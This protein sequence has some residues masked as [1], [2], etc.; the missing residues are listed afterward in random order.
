M[1]FIFCQPHI[2]LSRNSSF[3]DNRP[4]YI[5]PSHNWLP[6]I[7][8][9]KS[10]MRSYQIICGEWW[11][12]EYNSRTY[13]LSPSFWYVGFN[14]LDLFLITQLEYYKTSISVPLGC[15]YHALVSVDASTELQMS[16]S[17][18]VEYLKS[19]HPKFYFKG[20]FLDLQLNV[21]LIII[22]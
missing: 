1:Q 19:L 10:T 15:S 14:R 4:N 3:S 13:I 5:K 22:K 8:E 17:Y 18:P 21:S 9:N 6:R 7:K 11:L 12:D 20:F 2:I 16:E